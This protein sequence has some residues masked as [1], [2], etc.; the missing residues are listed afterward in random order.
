[1]SDYRNHWPELRRKLPR[2][3]RRMVVRGRVQLS[4]E[5]ED[6]RGSKWIRLAMR[7]LDEGS[8]TAEAQVVHQLIGPAQPEND[9]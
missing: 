5:Y 6:P 9:N 3:P 4:I 8:L 1:M 2:L 7:P